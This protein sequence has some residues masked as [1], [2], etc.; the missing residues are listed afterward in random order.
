M[1]LWKCSV[2]GSFAVPAGFDTLALT[3][4]KDE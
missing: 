2:F 4:E 3:S 1:S